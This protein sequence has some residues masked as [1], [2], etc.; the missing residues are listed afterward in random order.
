MNLVELFSGS[1]VMSRTF[2]GLGFTTFTLDIDPATCP[3]LAADIFDID[4]PV[5]APHLQDRLTVIWASP[6][7]TKWSYA[8]GS[9]CEFTRANTDPLSEDALMAV[10]MVK[11]TLL[12]IEELDPTYWFLENP[13][14]GALKDQDFMKQYPHVDVTY[15]SYDYPYQKRTRIWGRFPPSWVVRAGC[16]HARHPNIKSAK[17]AAARAVI[18][19]QL[20]CDIGQA[21]RRDNGRQLSTLED[22]S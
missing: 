8:N 10:E 1:Q 19:F 14:H 6:D 22:F 20:C 5:L 17:D 11:Q 3:D 13:F 2:G 9:D 15:C 4:S 7:C 21:C 18:P 16:S 12:L